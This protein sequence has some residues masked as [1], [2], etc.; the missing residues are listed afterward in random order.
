MNNG[1][2]QAE[3]KLLAKMPPETKEFKGKSYTNQRFVVEIPNKFGVDEVEFEAGEKAMLSLAVVPQNATINLSFVLS[4]RRW[5]KQDGTMAWF[6]KLKCIG[7]SSKESVKP[8]P[9]V[10]D[11]EP[12]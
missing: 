10:E 5:N 8:E 6:N 12:F 7:C 2:Y 11:E 1:I 9:T 3:G 4:G